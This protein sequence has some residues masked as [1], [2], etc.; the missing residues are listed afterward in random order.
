MTPAE[1][2]SYLARSVEQFAADRVRAGLS[3]RAEALSQARAELDR[4]LP[5]GLETPDHY[6]RAVLDEGTGERVGEVWYALERTGGTTQL[7]V[8][9]IGIDEAHRRRGFAQATLLL[10][11]GE[12]RRLGVPRIAL[13]VFGHNTGARSLYTKLGY[14]PTNIRM[15]KTL[16]P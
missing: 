3:E 1:A 7:F 9:W 16:P 6:F 10:L 2:E 4:L 15:A 13:H 12:A 11:E 5:R 14:V 8:C